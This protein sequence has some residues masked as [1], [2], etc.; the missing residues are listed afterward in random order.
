MLVV[1]VKLLMH[2]IFVQDLIQNGRLA[3]I[4]FF[5]FVL[6]ECFFK[7][8]CFK[9]VTVKKHDNIHVHMKLF[10]DPVSFSHL[11]GHFSPKNDPK[12]HFCHVI[13]RFSEMPGPI[14]FKVGMLVVHVVLLM[15]AIFVRDLIQNTGTNKSPFVLLYT[16]YCHTVLLLFKVH[17]CLTNSEHLRIDGC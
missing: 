4:L 8:I 13:K 3:A 16:N 15:H 6:F 10:F 9:V 14:L 7:T 2:T 1:H 12:S 5:A 17:V 11:G